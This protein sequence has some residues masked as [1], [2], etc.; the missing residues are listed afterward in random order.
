MKKGVGVGELMG[1]CAF[2][3]LF[4]ALIIHFLGIKIGLSF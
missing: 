3:V 4:D 1:I 2:K